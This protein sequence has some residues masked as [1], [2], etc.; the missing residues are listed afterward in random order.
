MKGKEA[1]NGASWSRTTKKRDDGGRGFVHDHS[2]KS[3]GTTSGLQLS[4]W[5]EAKSGRVQNKGREEE[6]TTETKHVR[7][8]HE[9][10]VCAL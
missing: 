3:N 5:S 8:R 7:T 6:T 1:R 2:K 10:V 9:D 4:K